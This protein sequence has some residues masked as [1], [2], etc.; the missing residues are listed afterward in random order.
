M[1][2][3][4]CICWSV[5]GWVWGGENTGKLL[6]QITGSLSK[7]SYFH[8]HNA[9][10]IYLCLLQKWFWRWCVGERMG[11]C[12]EGYGSFVLDNLPDLKWKQKSCREQRS[13]SRLI[14]LTDCSTSFFTTEGGFYWNH[15]HQMTEGRKTPLRI[16]S[17][18]L[19]RDNTISPNDGLWE[20]KNMSSEMICLKKIN[21]M[22]C[23]QI[24]ASQYSTKY[25][26]NT[27]SVT[28]IQM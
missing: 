6:D 18:L 28:I 21:R 26:T 13:A 17:C 16:T 22:C 5:S 11:G 10:V 4:L 19:K 12:A 9:K 7:H 2:K 8:F 25:N 1:F 20:M 27:N 3:S 15:V 24:T 14:L 23:S